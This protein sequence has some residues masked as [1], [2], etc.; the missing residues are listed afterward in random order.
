[1]ESRENADRAEPAH[2][3]VANGDDRRLFGMG[4][5]AFDGE[6]AGVAAAP[7]SSKPN[8]LC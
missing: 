6:D 8:L 2:H 7:I 3:V 4:G 5:H 1:M